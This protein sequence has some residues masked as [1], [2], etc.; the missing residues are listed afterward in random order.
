MAP[1][2]SASTAAL[3]LISVI[4]PT[5]SRPGRLA[6]CLAALVAQDYPAGRFEVVVVDDGSDAPLD[7]VVAACS[8]PVSL[9][10]LR[11]ANAGPG[12]AR[13]RGAAAARGALLAFTDDDCLPDPGWLGALARA[14]QAA[15]QDLLGGRVVNHD[16]R[17][18][19][20]ETSQL[21]LDGVYR[22]YARNPGPGQFFASNN[23]GVPAAGF[24]ALGGFDA[25]FRVA[26]EDRDLCDRWVAAGRNLRY[27]PDAVV[28]HAPLLDLGRFARQHYNYGRGAFHYHR[29]RRRRGRAGSATALGQHARFLVEVGR[30][31]A[32]R[33][34]AERLRIGA[35]LLLW[36][37]ANAAGYLAGALSAKRL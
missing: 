18:P 22:Y 14:H 15:P 16:A 29:A 34:A 24:C 1:V 20:A 12:A 26:S 27:A 13:N 19:C 37:G 10:L 11:Q 4:V 17:N 23:M 21:I 2:Q 3:P 31:L 32:Q 6:N 30:G 35:L 7:E 5:F 33:R 9:A 36:Q 25:D 28:R 8:G